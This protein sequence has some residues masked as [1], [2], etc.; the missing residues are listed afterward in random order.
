MVYINYFFLFL[1]GFGSVGHLIGTFKYTEKG[2]G[3]F[4]WSLSGVLAGLLLLAFNVLRFQEPGNGTFTV[5]SLCGNIFWAIIVLLFGQS[6]K[7]I[8]DPRV[9]I[10]LLA[11]IG[12][13]VFCLPYFF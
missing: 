5:I 11:A 1:L 4:V 3:L 9:L 12:L 7:N 6:I 2:S 13:A 8:K 10:H